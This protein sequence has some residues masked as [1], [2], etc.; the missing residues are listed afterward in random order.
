MANIGTDF[1]AI[2]N[3]AYSSTG[4]GRVYGVEAYVQQQLVNRLFYVASATVYKSEFSGADGVF[5][6]STWDYGYILS[7]TIGYKF[8]RNWDVG[9]KYRIAGGQPYTPFDLDR[10]RALYFT[11][12]GG[13][14]D[15]TRLNS[16]R[17]PIFQ[18]LDLRVDKRYNFRNT[19]LTFFLD[20]QNVFKYKTPSLPKYTFERTADNSGFVTTDGNAPRADGSNTLPLI[21]DERSATIVPALGFIFEF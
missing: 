10:S 20:F 5:I 1:S 18:Q 13:V 4:K 11:L 8:G 19:S 2:G 14:Y 3:E 15:Y 17:L 6:P 21:L 12:G 16:E 7:S 9:I